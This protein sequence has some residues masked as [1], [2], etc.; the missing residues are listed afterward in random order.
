MNHHALRLVDNH[1]AFVLKHNVKGNVL[2]LNIKIFGR[3]RTNRNNITFAKNI[4]A[5]NTFFVYGSSLSLKMP[6]SPKMR[7]ALADALNS[8]GNVTSWNITAKEKQM[9]P[10][11]IRTAPVFL[12][13][14]NPIRINGHASVEPRLATGTIAVRSV[15]GK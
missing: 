7:N 10:R 1:K 3:R 14:N 11:L 5:F 13:K 4:V 8:T 2:R 15:S 6:C 9:I 12:V